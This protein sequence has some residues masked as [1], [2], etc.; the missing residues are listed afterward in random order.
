MDRGGDRVGMGCLILEVLPFFNSDKTSY[1][2]RVS[3]LVIHHLR[4]INDLFLSKS[5]E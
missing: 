4:V 3:S 1:D 2:K 5:Y